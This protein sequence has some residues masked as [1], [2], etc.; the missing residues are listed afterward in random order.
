[1]VCPRFRVC[2]SLAAWAWAPQTW[3][4]EGCEVAR[5]R[6]LLLIVVASTVQHSESTDLEEPRKTV[7]ADG[8]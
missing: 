4:G 1:M 2:L 3:P 6:P 5:T 8:V 7:P